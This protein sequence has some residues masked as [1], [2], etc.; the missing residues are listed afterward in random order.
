MTKKAIIQQYV[1]EVKN[2]LVCSKSLKVIFFKDLKERIASSQ[3]PGREITR[4][5]LCAEFGS[6]EEIAAGFFDREDYKNLLHSA[7]IRSV[8]WRT[9]SILMAILLLLSILFTV[10]VIRESATTVTVTNPIIIQ[11]TQEEQVK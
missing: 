9:V 5:A 6:P 1:S 2:T 4:E 10:C 8:R 11:Q 3:S 7:K